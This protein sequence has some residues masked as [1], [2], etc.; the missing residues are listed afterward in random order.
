MATTNIPL[1]RDTWTL[2]G[3]GPLSSLMLTCSQAF[4][5][6]ATSGSAPTIDFPHQ[7]KGTEPL[8]LVVASGETVWARTDRGRATMA[9]DATVEE[10]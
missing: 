9:V 5:F 2:V 6:A 3:T 8:G 4:A 1:P 10:V 7:H